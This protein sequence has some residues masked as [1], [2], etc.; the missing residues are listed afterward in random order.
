MLYYA[1]AL[2]RIGNVDS[3]D[4]TLDF[5]PAERERG[6][7]VNSAAISFSWRDHAFFLVD[8]PWHLDF[9]YEVQR[10][11]R[12]TDGVIVIVDAVAGVQPQT[13]TVWRQADQYGI[14]RIVFINKMD[15]SGADFAAA[16][17]SLETRLRAKVAALHMPVVDKQTGDWTGYVD[18]VTMELVERPR[19]ASP[20]DSRPDR[21]QIRS[22]IR[23]QSVDSVQHPHARAFEAREHLIEKL[24][25]VDDELMDLWA[26]GSDIDSDSIKASVRRASLN[27]DLVP[28]L[29][30]SALKNFGVQPLLDAAVDYL[31]SPLERPPVHATRI[32]DGSALSI[33]SN[34][35]G[36]L[37]ALAFKV[38]HDSHRGKLVFMRAFSGH[39]NDRKATFYNTSARKTEV[40]TALLRIMADDA[41]HVDEIHTGDIFAAVS[42]LALF[43]SIYR[44]IYA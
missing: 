3:G 34:P 18:L 24:A 25:D 40:P 2:Q 11:L 20:G 10:A 23:H 39:L 41:I 19:V 22:P 35:V 44:T 15:R 4:T 32:A 26:G 36:Q 16:V 17:V 33:P 14:P 8:S 1:G 21:K 37:F 12:V 6:I 38:T 31:P 7:T 28:V 13:E 5:L 27:R 9:T 30:G 42:F 29:C 43:D